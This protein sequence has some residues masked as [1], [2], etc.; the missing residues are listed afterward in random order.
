MPSTA[1]PSTSTGRSSHA[2]PIAAVA[3]AH[4]ILAVDFA[5]VDTDFLR[6]FY[7]LI[8]IE[9]ESR[10]EHITGITAH[11]TETWATQQARNLLMDLGDRA[12]QF[13]LLIR[14]RAAPPCIDGARQPQRRDRL[15]GIIHKYLQVA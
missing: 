3:R 15:G 4:A 10:R 2:H 6:R 8:V 12:A 11:P 7:V 9:H 14:G 5:H 13:R 1:E